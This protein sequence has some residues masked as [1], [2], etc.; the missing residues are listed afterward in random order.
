[1]P[2]VSQ[3]QKE[4][5]LPPPPPTD[6]ELQA[7]LDEALDTDPQLR[8]ELALTL[9]DPND[10]TAMP[11]EED[12]GSGD[13]EHPIAT[14]A[15]DTLLPP[16]KAAGR[17]VVNALNAGWKTLHMLALPEFKKD[18]SF[19]DWYAKPQPSASGPVVS[20]DKINK[21]F[22]A[23]KGGSLGFVE[24]ASQFAA[25]M[26][27]GMK[28]LKWVKAAT[29]LGQ[30]TKA[31]GAGFIAD[32]AFFDPYQERLS[33]LIQEWQPNGLT[34]FLQ[35][36][37]DDS[38][39]E[40]RLK[41]G[42]EGLV[43]GATLDSVL[44]GFRALKAKLKGDTKG[45]Q[46]AMEKAAE[47]AEI[48]APDDVV[49]VVEGDD[50]R[51]SVVPA[52]DQPKPDEGGGLF[53]DDDESTVAFADKD[54]TAIAQEVRDPYIRAT[55]D[56][57]MAKLPPIQED[58]VDS[59]GFPKFKPKPPEV[60]AKPVS[61]GVKPP[62]PEAK[63]SGEG[64]SLQRPTKAPSGLN[65]TVKRPDVPSFSSRGEAERYAASQ[66]FVAKNQMKKPGVLE[67]GDADAFLKAFKAYKENPDGRDFKE[68]LD[69][70]G[71]NINYASQPEDVVNVVKA[72]V[73]LMPEPMHVARGKVKT[74]KETADEAD[75]IFRDISGDEVLQAAARIWGNTEKLP[76]HI[77]GL[78]VVMW[79]QAQNVKKLSQIAELAPD[80][81]G[82][83]DEL[84]KALDSMLELHAYV[85]GTSSN[86][87]RA[88]NIHKRPLGEAMQEA[89]ESASKGE[90][91]AKGEATN[92]DAPKAKESHR[93]PST[94]K[95][96]EGLSRDE[97]RSLARAI[98]LADGDPAEILAI[99]RGPKGVPKEAAKDPA[100]RKKWID[101]VLTVRMEAMLSGPKTHVTN[102]INNTLVAFQRPAEYWW[103]GVRSSNPELRQ[104]GADMYAGLLEN[105]RESWTAAKKSFM[106]GENVLDKDMRTVETG[107][108]LTPWDSTSWLGRIAR[109]PSRFLLTSDEFFKQMNYRANLRAQ[110][111]RK[112]RGEGVTDPAEISRRL[113]DD[114]QWGFDPEGGAVN[115][116]AL[117]YSRVA[118]FTNELEYGWGK[119]F[120]EVAQKHPSFRIVMPFIR[121]PTN[122]FRYAWQRTPVLNRLN[123]EMAADL[124]AGGE[125]AAIAKAK[126]EMGYAMWSTAAILA[127]S[128]QITGRG[129]AD[130]ELNRQWKEAG[131]QPYSL[132]VGDRWV[133]FR[134]GDPIFTSL[135][136]VADTVQMWGELN[137]DQR[138][139]YGAAVIATLSS[140]LTSKTYMQGMTDFF[141]AVSSG[142]AA[143][144]ANLVENTVGSFVPNVLRQG[145]PDDSI[146]ETRGMLDELMGRLPG[147]SETLEP[148]RN[149]F[150][151]KVMRP[152]SYVNNTFNPFTVSGKV[153]NENV[154]HELVKLGRAMTMPAEKRFG[155][156]V[157]LTDRS[158]FNDGPNEN[159]SPYDRMLELLANPGDG[160]PSLR[161]K[162]EDIVHS[163]AYQNA[164]AEDVS[165]PGGLKHRL[166]SQ[167][168]AA[169][170]Q[171]AFAQV[172]SEYPSLLQAC[173]QA[174]ELKGAGGGGGA[175]AMDDVMDKYD[176]LFVK[177]KRQRK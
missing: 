78:R 71:F 60:G 129:P 9:G 110:I 177:P 159:Q 131:N 102:A 117:Q 87:A 21:W 84:A 111:L 145:N 124:A 77:D 5:N 122:I 119:T 53:K 52:V 104:M 29:R 8:E 80:D 64:T 34:E 51:F 167:I 67:P 75:E 35:A 97:V 168:I 24:G 1:M 63:P 3:A 133:S 58:S 50:G 6:E 128:G 163:E 54:T 76:A 20:E 106:A 135:G 112:A 161:E 44:W 136:M 162:V 13:G 73:D 99:L 56:E 26:A 109:A 123:K 149:L 31:A 113:K 93:A 143:D 91:V 155:G 59:M 151:E 103:A 49:K 57:L 79:K 95:A 28:A 142:R 134:R 46:E 85:A 83:V 121:T 100:T 7:G 170:Q 105:L 81:A 157:D 146:R 175:T 89:V 36:D 152:P 115:P 4:V 169:E 55:A 37:K 176:Q 173:N 25:G 90:G 165:G 82:A 10:A 126:V 18:D 138:S 61:D 23:A 127:L 141:E 40:G 147:F 92:A 153:T 88:L 62:E 14:W 66:N 130:K 108:Q 69:T 139:N 70:Y 166:V 172:L 39:I 68:L 164:P 72:L 42:L 45:M 116:L 156:L 15:K 120:Q 16:A 160:R 171:I 2:D 65:D 74:W 148:R 118:T 43:T 94:H 32:S 11:N 33:N 12:P 101:F 144:A 30:T 114:F 154:A 27:V 96:T 137:D 158:T 86:T 19:M 17:G 132:R 140:N 98:Y 47:V 38:E 107:K 48:P 41:A 22:G 150:G 174:R 125:R